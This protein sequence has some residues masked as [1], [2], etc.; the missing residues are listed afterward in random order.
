MKSLLLATLF[1]ASTASAAEIDAAVATGT[2]YAI[3]DAEPGPGR[4]RAARH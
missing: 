1:A 2:I 3:T 4:H